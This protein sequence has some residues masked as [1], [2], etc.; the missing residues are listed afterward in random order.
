MLR[1]R[2]RESENI[3]HSR[4]LDSGGFMQCNAFHTPDLQPAPEQAMVSFNKKF[5]AI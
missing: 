3:E 2:G 1:I 5:M 4:G